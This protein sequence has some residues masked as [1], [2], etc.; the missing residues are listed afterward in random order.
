[1]SLVIQSIQNH[2]D[3]LSHFTDLGI[4]YKSR[5]CGKDGTIFIFN[6]DQLTKYP[7]N[8]VKYKKNS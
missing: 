8:D 7:K 3:D 6:Y 1:M 5:D 2:N 4:K